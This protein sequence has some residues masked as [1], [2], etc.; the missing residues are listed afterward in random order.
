MEGGEEDLMKWLN[1]CFTKL[2]RVSY[3]AYMNY[4]VQLMVIG[5]IDSGLFQLQCH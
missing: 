3:L 5:I 1:N 4:K 2:V